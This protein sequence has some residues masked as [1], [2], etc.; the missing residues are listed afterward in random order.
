[1]R[2]S[3]FFKLLGAFLLVVIIGSLTIAMLSSQATQNAFQLYTTRSGQVWA[4]RLAP[5]LAD[6]Y[7]QNKSW[8]GVSDYIQNNLSTSVSPGMMGGGMHGNG[9][10]NM[11]ILMEQ[12]LILTD[13]AGLVLADTSAELNGQT[14]SST[15]LLNGFPITL[16][17]NTVGVII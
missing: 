1:M 14:L 9:N 10:G 16:N 5:Y 8:I 3:L 15:G 12:R 7:S 11:G 4:A 6:Y 2:F 13:S 17:G